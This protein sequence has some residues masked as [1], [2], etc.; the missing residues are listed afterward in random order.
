MCA[1]ACL[2]MCAP[3]AQFPSE[4]ELELRR[5]DLTSTIRRST[6]LLFARR[7]RR[8][9]RAQWFRQVH[10]PERY[11][12][13]PRRE[14]CPARGETGTVKQ[15]V[16]PVRVEGR[17]IESDGAVPPA[18][19]YP[20]QSPDPVRGF[21]QD[22]VC[23]VTQAARILGRIEAARLTIIYFW[24]KLCTLVCLFHEKDGR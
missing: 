9:H 13:R 14:R 1:C 12:L 3:D 15:S 22:S 24:S 17:E 2:C 20:H 5:I 8:H 4:V 11:P 23:V 16:V 6:R 7:P 18:L 10:P 21:P 19:Y